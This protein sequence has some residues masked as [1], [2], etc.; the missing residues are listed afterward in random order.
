M[1]DE[2]SLY[3]AEYRRLFEA[4]Y[5]KS[6]ADIEYLG[7]KPRVGLAFEKRNGKLLLR[8]SIEEKVFFSESDFLIGDRLFLVQSTLQAVEN[9]L[10]WFFINGV[11]FREKRV[12]LFSLLYEYPHISADSRYFSSVSEKRTGNSNVFVTD[13]NTG[14]IT[15]YD[16]PQH[17]EF[18]PQTLGDQL[19]YLQS[20]EGA[21]ELKRTS[22][23]E[24]KNEVTSLYEGDIT[25]FRIYGSTLY[26]S[27]GNRIYSMPAVG[28]ITPELGAT[29]EHT[30]SIQS[31][32]VCKDYW[33]L[34]LLNGES[35][36]DLYLYN[37]EQKTGFYISTTLC[38]EVDVCV[39]RD[40][41]KILY[42]SNPE[43]YFNLFVI[44]METNRIS[45]L[46]NNHYDEFY[47]AFTPNSTGIIFSRYETR[48]EPYFVAL[49]IQ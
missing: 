34:S 3:I 38:Q 49:T 48:S 6:A 41:K 27:E 45:R 44:D 12:G 5:L 20:L 25:C 35:Q 36:Y 14:K 17:S 40:G 42:S 24:D 11:D 33:I 46:T 13:L 31:F 1:T 47:G 4:E 30:T 37:P 2:E 29:F 10:I 26:W 8:A 7:T 16:I 15:W 9:L 18:F 19:Y 43:G 21:R 32:D 23:S 39:T 22:I 28:G